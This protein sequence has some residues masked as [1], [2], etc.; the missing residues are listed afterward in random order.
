MLITKSAAVADKYPSAEVIGIDLSPIQPPWVPPNLRFVVDDLE[1]EWLY[2][3]NHF[4]YVHIRH[5]LHSVKNPVKL[6][7]RALK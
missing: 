4:D 5:T 7:E 3:Q 1:D 6:M 2:P